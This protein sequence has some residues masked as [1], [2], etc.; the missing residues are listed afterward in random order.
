MFRKFISVVPLVLSLLISKNQAQNTPRDWENPA[1]FARGQEEPHATLMPFHTP[2]EAVK[3]QLKTSRYCLLLNGTWKFHFADIPEE[4]PAD[5][6]RTDYDVSNWHNIIVPGNWQMQGFGWA[7]FRNVHQPFKANPPY[8]PSAYNPTGS[9][10]RTFFIPEAWKDRKVFLHF[11]GVKS[12]STVWINGKEAGYNEGGM[13]PAEYDITP[14]LRRGQNVIAVRVFGYSDGTYLECQDMWRLFGIHRDVYLMATPEVHIR[15]FYATTDFD[16]RYR[17]A[18][19]NLRAEIK[20]HGHEPRKNVALRA[21]L[22]DADSRPVFQQLPAKENLEIAAGGTVLVEISKRIVQPAKWSAEDPNLYTLVL[23]LDGPD[24]R[25]MEFLAG[26]V[27]FREVEIK[28]QAIWINGSRVKFNGVNSHVHHPVTGRTMDTGTMRKDLSLMKQFNINCVR[29]SH[30]PPNA[31]Y[32]DMADE[33]GMYI[34]D[35]TGDEAHATEYLSDNP[36]WRSAYVNRGRKMV[37]RDRNHPSV[38]IW[39]AGNESGSGENIAAVIR[40]GKRLDPSRPGWCYGGNKDLLP[41]ED[42]VGPRYPDIDALQQVGL[43]PPSKDPRPS[44][45]DEYLAA[46]GNSLG[47]LEEYWDLIWKHPRLTG[48]AIWDW[49]SPG[50]A[51]KVI[52]TPD[53]SPRQNRAALLGRS[54]LVPGRFGNAV[55]LSGHDD[56]VEP[57]NDPALDIQEGRLTLETWVFPRRWNGYGALVMKGDHQYGLLQKD[58]KTVEFYIQDGGRISAPAPVPDAWEFRWHHLAGVYDGA[59][60]RLYV[61]GKLAGSNRHA[62]KMETSPYP[63]AIGRSTELYG[64]EHEG[65]LSN[66]VI[67]NVRIFA[68]ALTA[69]E[70][71]T[72]SE[73]LRQAAVLWLDFDETM[74][75]GDFF[76]LGIG[77][78]AYGLVWPDRR[79]QPEL[80]QLK[81]SPQPV[82]IETVDVLRGTVRITNR[83]NFKNL[84]ELET[85]W[86]IESDAKILQ[87]GTIAL[88]VPPGK[89]RIVRIPYTRPTLDPG[90]EAHLLVSLRLPD[91]TAWAPAGHEVAWEQFTLA[92]P[93]P[94]MAEENTGSLSV[95]EGEKT[96]D[97]S[98]KDFRYVFD[99]TI[100]TLSSI[101]F[102]NA[103]LIKTG[104]KLN[105]WRAPISNETE[106]HWGGKP[107]VE[108]WR[109]AG[110]DRLTIRVLEVRV[111]QEPSRVVLDVRT[112]AQAPGKESGFESGFTCVFLGSGDLLIDHR[113][114]PFGK[115]PDWLP[116]IGIQ[117]TLNDALDKFSWYG[118]G[119]F[120]TYPDR[121]SG[122]KVGVFTGTVD[123]QYSPYLEPQDYGNKTDVR[124]A[125]LTDTEG[126]GLFVAGQDLLN[127][128]VHHYS[129][130][131]LTRARFPFQ[132]VKQDG[133]TLNI[134]H[135]VCGLGETPIHTQPKYRVLSQ[136]YSY[137]I[138]L[139]PFDGN[140]IS[141]AELGRQRVE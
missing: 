6:Y 3:N 104:P 95:R 74:E 124:W 100:G 116:K 42:I 138:R 57:Y 24:G 32:L 55:S 132:L 67:D 76:S 86:R 14:Y 10:R 118:R 18:D 29:T 77:G 112:A 91:A 22:F 63:V 59:E 85:A 78:R 83:Y 64:Q 53:L 4:A 39:S 134:D 80:W 136:D 40:E 19:L 92:N 119:P 120:E 72:A 121:K 5:F 110:L 52:L 47:N 98:G 1:V 73:A 127:V 140:K 12:A 126:I 9:Y 46:T 89:N 41:F 34:V 58:A 81:K 129:T 66:A 50:I 107:M 108:Q 97:I 102:K 31:E 133:V 37:L 27:G 79:V 51:Q 20:N 94:K 48:G 44:F 131:N 106:R 141:A 70:I 8:V 15:D 36:D 33:L 130:D 17:D 35:E 30:Y 43:V 105:V 84:N 45:M 99:K 21:S 113:V 13:E 7:Q 38:V 54:R 69:E 96:I 123:E 23:E 61:D 56:W 87:S 115:M 11:E 71:G 114:K 28:N 101:Q 68:K 49:V 111:R 117:L 137:R 93:S 139:R 82:N 62:G 25:P 125:A 109:K 60:L 135:R 16:S 26:R 103:E 122:A 90:A 65:E 128:S 88:D 75:Q 2:E